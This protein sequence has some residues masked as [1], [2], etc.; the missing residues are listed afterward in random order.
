MQL[1]RLFKDWKFSFARFDAPTD[2]VR[3]PHTLDRGQELSPVL[4]ED[5][6]PTEC[7]VSLCK[8]IDELSATSRDVFSDITEV[9]PSSD[10]AQFQ[11][12]DTASMS[13]PYERAHLISKS[14]VS[15]PSLV[16][17]LDAAF[18]A[19][20]EAIFRIS[21]T[22]VQGLLAKYRDDLNTNDSNFV[23]MTR[24]FHNLFDGLIGTQAIIAGGKRR[25]IAAGMVMILL[26]PEHVQQGVDGAFNPKSRRCTLLHCYRAALSLFCALQ[27]RESSLPC[28]PH[29]QQECC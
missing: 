16:D 1:E 14:L 29:C 24:R 5:Y 20:S 9:P 4:L 7:T 11:A 10:L 17:E 15:D 19:Q 26:I 6:N 2:V 25:K 3:R 28:G 18:W 27:S 12:V 22:E 23:A 13:L 21:K 8:G